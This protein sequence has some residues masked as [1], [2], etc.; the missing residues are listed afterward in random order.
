MILGIFIGGYLVGAMFSFALFAF[1]VVLGG[2]NSDVWKPI[3]LAAIWPVGL[4]MF[5]TGRI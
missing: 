5:C 3:A 2:K 1:F 4:W